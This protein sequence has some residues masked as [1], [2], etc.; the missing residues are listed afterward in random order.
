[1][2]FHNWSLK[3][4]KEYKARPVE[5]LRLCAGCTAYRGSRGIAVLY[6]L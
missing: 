6:R 5:A 1:M 3:F 2:E 4:V